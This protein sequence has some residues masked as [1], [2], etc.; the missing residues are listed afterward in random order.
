MSGMQSRFG[1]RAPVLRLAVEIAVAAIGVALLAFALAA[2]QA[3]WD[4]H[5]LPVFFLSRAAYVMGETWARIAAGV[6][7]IVLAFIVRPILGRFAARTRPARFLADLGMALLAIVLALSVSELVLRQTFSRAAE[8]DPAGQE[9]LRQPDAERG[10]TFVPSRVGHLVTAGRDIAYAFDAGG[11][12][13]R[14]LGDS[15]DPEKPTILFTGE[16]IVSGYGLPW[17]Q[18]IP[19]Q[20]AAA[21]GVQ[22]ANMAVFGYATDQA[23][24]RV[25]RALPQ[26]AK[27]VAVVSLF[28]PGLLFRNFDDDR[29]HLDGKL[30]LQ[31]AVHRWRLAALVRW[32]VPF[33]SSDDIANCIASTRAVLAAT[34]QAARAHGAIPLIVVPQFGPESEAERMLRKRVLDEGGLDYVLVP[35]DPHWR[36]PSDPHPDARATHTI[37][38]AIAARLA[39][40]K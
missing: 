6:L 8:E 26:F 1:P 37:A 20:T 10:W 17:E 31:P 22:A 40:R 32:L 5:F 36:I 38:M 16:S 27:P 33:H 11:Y 30:T 21:L 4:A 39:S 24:L 7:G 13:V 29:P 25:A 2:R 19:A 35:I 14:T 12:R 18:T 23:Y 28:M 3:W 15:V 34:A 9:P